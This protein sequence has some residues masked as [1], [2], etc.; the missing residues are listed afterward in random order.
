MR[1]T[2][3]LLILIVVACTNT[4]AGQNGYPATINVTGHSL[5]TGTMNWDWSLGETL[6]LQTTNSP[7]LICINTGYLQ[8][9]FGIGIDHKILESNTTFK[10]GPNPVNQVLK[11]NSNQNGIVILKV[12][13]LNQDGQLYKILQGPFSG[14]Q[15]EQT[16]SFAS[17][18]TGSY[19]IVIY[20]VVGNSFSTMKVFKI[21]KL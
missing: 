17:A 19:F 20:Y 8:N 7:S 3:T 1:N 14:I 12:E 16:I 10:I 13:I 21:I 2:I 11:I 9:D 4:L 6:M 15:F 5:S 18:N